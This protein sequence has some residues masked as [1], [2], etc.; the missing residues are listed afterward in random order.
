MKDGIIMISVP[1]TTT[2]ED[3]KQIREQYKNNNDKLN[4][5]ISGNSDFKETLYDFLKTATNP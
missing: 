4:I 3:I 5:L 2:T 1:A